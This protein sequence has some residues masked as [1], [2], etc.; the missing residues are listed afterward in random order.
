MFVIHLEVG[1][2]QNAPQR[3]PDR[4]VAPSSRAQ[5]ALFEF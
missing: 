1:V 4:A 3:L 5:A 2:F